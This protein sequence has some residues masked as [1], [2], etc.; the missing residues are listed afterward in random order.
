MCGA[1]IEVVDAVLA[2]DD[3]LLETLARLHSGDGR[4]RSVLTTHDVH[5]HVD[6]RRIAVAAVSSP[7]GAEA[8]LAEA[9]EAGG[10]GDT[11]GVHAAGG[12]EDLTHGGCV[13]GRRKSVDA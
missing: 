13:D 10:G 8:G 6:R 7:G 1:G 5:T 12:T 4:L 2:A 3:L 11:L 9:H